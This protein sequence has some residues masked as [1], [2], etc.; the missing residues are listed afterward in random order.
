MS[1]LYSRALA[2][3]SQDILS[4]AVIRWNASVSCDYFGNNFGHYH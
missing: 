3:A 4:A 2:A 1:W